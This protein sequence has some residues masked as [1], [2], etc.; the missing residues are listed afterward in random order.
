VLPASPELVSRHVGSNRVA[1]SPVVT[2]EPRRRKFHQPVL[3]TVPLPKA[4]Q[5]GMINQY[6]SS[7][8]TSPPNLRLLCSVFGMCYWIR[9]QRLLGSG[10]LFEGLVTQR[11]LWSR[12][13]SSG[14]YLGLDARRECLSI[15]C[16]RG[17]S[18]D[19]SVNIGAIHG[20]TFCFYWSAPSFWIGLKRRATRGSDVTITYVYTFRNGR[21]TKSLHRI[22]P[23]YC[24]WWYLNPT[25]RRWL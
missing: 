4:F 20:S 10:L 18:M 9:V 1:V 13:F 21:R 19:R 25:R 3:L 17:W 12:G 7:G 22:H 23:S 5:R 14:I 11:G 8:G 6:S 16:T 24:W 2:L 15:C